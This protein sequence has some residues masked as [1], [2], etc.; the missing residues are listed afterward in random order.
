MHES[1]NDLVIDAIQPDM[2][3]INFLRI[4]AHHLN[5]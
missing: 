4:V 5:T 1:L 3:L 2:R